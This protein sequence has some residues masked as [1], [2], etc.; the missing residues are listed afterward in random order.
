[1]ETMSGSILSMMLLSMLMQGQPPSM[2]E[3][4]STAEASKEA[5]PE[6]P[7]R[8]DSLDS[9]LNTLRSQWLEPLNLTFSPSV[10]YTWQRSTKVRPGFP[11]ARSMIWFGA[12]GV[13]SVW[14]EPSSS[15]QLTYSL[16]GNTG[17]GGST[18]PYLGQAVG[19]PDYV[20]N[21]LV[22]NRIGLYELYWTQAMFDQKLKIRV[23]KFEDQSYFDKNTIAYN[24]VTGFMSENFNEQIVI[25]FPNYAF[26]VNLQWDVSPDLVIRAG[27]MN[28]NDA[29]NN[30]GF[31]GL[32]SSNL[33]TMAEFDLTVRPEIDGQSR[34]GHW[35]LTPWYNSEDGEGGS[36]DIHG[37]GICL[38]MDQE[39]CDQV[40]VFGRL[41]WGQNQATR[42]NFAVSIGFAMSEPFGIKSNHTGLAIGYSKLT[43]IARREVGLPPIPGEQLMLEWYWRAELTDR[44]DAGPVVQVIRDPGAGI[45]TAVIWGLR[46][47]LSF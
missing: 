40:S 27:T 31:E 16:Y 20:N 18:F 42:S 19:N 17:L 43:A 35:R 13:W 37:W 24:P 10:G 47:S 3:S 21:I 8:S 39:I 4:L 30:A 6:A 29:N 33:L 5:A 9:M 23:G 2:V 45:D 28:S 26:G 14:D 34:T 22:P 25:P 7:Q 11:H 46:T 38:N 32:S 15:G 41:G 36:P 44:F 12:T 1:M